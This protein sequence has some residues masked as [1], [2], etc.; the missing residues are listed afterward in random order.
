VIVGLTGGICSGKSTASAVLRRL[1][2]AL[3]DCDDLARY[4]ADFDPDVRGAIRAAWPQAFHPAGGLDRGALAGVVFSDAQQRRRLEQILHPP[5]LDSVERNVSAERQGGR[6]LVV[7][8]PLLFELG[9]QGLFDATWLV[10]CSPATQLARLMQRNGLDEPT[11]RR[12]IA[13]QWPLEQKTPLATLVLS[14]DAKIADLQAGVEAAW[15]G[16]LKAC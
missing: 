4:L 8:V 15:E 11:A 7:V 10:A 9:M 6:H 16:V 12:W 13:A 2:A 1:G 5:I 3:I 14:N